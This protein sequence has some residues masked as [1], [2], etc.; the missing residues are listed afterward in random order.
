VTDILALEPL[1]N[2]LHGSVH[3]RSAT[4]RWLP[5]GLRDGVATRRAIE[6]APVMG[7]GCVDLVKGWPGR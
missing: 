1:R 3:E 5:C 6:G 4:V 7:V 2:R